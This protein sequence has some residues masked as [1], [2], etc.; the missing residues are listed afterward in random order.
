MAS[1]LLVLLPLAALLPLALVVLLVLAVTSRPDGEIGPATAAARRHAVT[2]GVLAVVA[3]VGAV[4][5]WAALARSVDGLGAG[6]LLAA[7][8]LVAACAHT[9]VLALTEVTWPRPTGTRRSGLLVRR[10]VTDV[11]PRPALMAA[12]VLAG[13]VVVTGLVG[14]AVADGT[15]RSLT[16]AWDG[17]DGLVGSSSAGPFPGAFFVVP[18]LAG[19]V[20]LVAL[21]AL[22]LHLVVSRPAVTAADIATDT[23]LRRAGAHRVL[24]G[25]ASGAGLTLAGLLLT[26]GNAVRGVA[27]DAGALGLVGVGLAVVGGLAGVAGLLVLAVPAPRVPA[28]APVPAQVPAVPA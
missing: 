4:A 5:G 27:D 15:G 23:A 14:T 17:Q 8:F 28:P 9:L 22:A 1:G 11:L 16:R 25:A 3:A 10:R 21:V 19:L 7:V 20:A 26:A 2:G 13:A 18:V 6:R 12:A 24:R